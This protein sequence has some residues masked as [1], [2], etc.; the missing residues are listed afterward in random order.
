MQAD[1]AVIA[2]GGN[3]L[4]RPGERGTPAEQLARVRDVARGLRALA[5]D[6]ELVLTHGNGPQVGRVL[7]RSDL[8]AGEVPG[9]PLDLAV[10]ST[11]GSIGLMLQQAVAEA[12]GR[13]AVT[14]LTQTVV[15]RDDPDF[16]DPSK[17]V[18][19]FY[20]EAEARRRALELGWQVKEDPGRGWRRVVPSPQPRAIVE[21]PAIRALLAAGVVVIAAGGGGVPVVAL[22][23]TLA[24]VEAVVDKDRASALLAAQLGAPRLVILT[25][26]D[27]VMVD[28][29]GP[30]QRA[31][32]AAGRQ[33]L[34]AH[35]A[36]GQ[37]PPGS[38]GPKIEAA[39]S[40]LDGGGREVLITSPERLP[41]A[42]A[43]RRG[44]R[45]R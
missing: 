6:T 19:R 4:I 11:Q 12:L 45:V 43:G 39:L 42:L 9:V 33:E 24:G 26:V 8:C 23:G 30:G 31:L 7:L 18:G 29:G 13:P 32:T 38:M 34:A 10:A 27:E 2:L 16:A 15:D 14:V 21:L 1:R 25:G 17:Y 35:L 28:F 5:A 37:F 44:T 36:A 41:E 20:T 3:A 22:H 40:F